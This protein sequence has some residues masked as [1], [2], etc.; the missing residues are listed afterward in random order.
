MRPKALKLVFKA[1]PMQY[2]FGTAWTALAFWV[3]WAG[4]INF[5]LFR[6]IWFDFNDAVKFIFEITKNGLPR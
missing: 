5:E 3:L 6:E 4:G 1:M 2:F